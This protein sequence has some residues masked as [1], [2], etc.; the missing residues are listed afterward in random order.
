MTPVAASVT[1][2][3]QSP[4]KVAR[5]LGATAARVAR[6]SGGLVFAS[7]QMAADLG[8][9][10]EA[11][12]EARLGFPWLLAS[13][14][15]V[16][17]ERGEI[18]D[19]SA[20][21]GL[22]WSGHECR[23]AVVE[24]SGPAELGRGLYAAISHSPPRS[25]HRA[26]LVFVRPEAHG[27]DLLGP[28]EV[29]EDQVFGAGTA[30]EASVM[31]LSRD[32]SLR[33]G[34]GAVLAIEGPASP[35]IRVS[36][37]CRLVTPLYRITEV[38]GSLLLG[39]DDAPALGA[40]SSELLGEQ[41]VLAAL[42]TPEAESSLGRP[43]ILLRGIQGVDP[44][45]RALVISGE[46]SVGMRFGFAVRDPVAARADLESVARGLRQA[47][48]GSAPRFAVYLNCAAR[49]SSLYGSYDVDTRILRSSLPDTPIV[50][51]QSSFEIAP[52]GGRPA[53]HLYSGVLGLFTTPS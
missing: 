51:M 8:R 50:G 31:G 1:L 32:G 44:D 35:I 3:A 5:E 10:A 12:G 28:L 45:Q 17:T 13:G 46:L 22:V 41:M 6:P 39:L 4:L 48:A 15:G 52:H 30:G 25:R 49:G 27:P 20:A 19:Q 29:L 18:E 14:A 16:L 34:Q 9:L 21:C 36:P 26:V 47:T 11:L 23:L 2:R 53:L 24:A 37:A 42:G 43:E 40:L 38:R 7:G 33:V